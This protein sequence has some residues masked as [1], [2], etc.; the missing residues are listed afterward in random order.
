MKGIYVQS[1]LFSFNFDKM[2]T[3]EMRENLNERLKTNGQESLN[4]TRVLGTTVNQKV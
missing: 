1:T 3:G 2:R 4:L